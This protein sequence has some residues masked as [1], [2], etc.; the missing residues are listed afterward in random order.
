MTQPFD[1][2][3]LKTFD[4]TAEIDIETS[5]GDGAPVHW[6]SIWI[7]VDGD[8]VYVRSVRGPAGRWFRELTANP[9]GAVHAGGN[10]VPVQAHAAT[11][12]ATVAR[13][14]EALNQK[15]QA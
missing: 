9:A 5:R 6:T 14:S 7:V 10:S 1:Q 8:S 15:Y 12:P 11:D 2:H 13:V 4:Q 3:T